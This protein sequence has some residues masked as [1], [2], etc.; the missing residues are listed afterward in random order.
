MRWAD[1]E[2]GFGLLFLSAGRHEVM[3]TRGRLYLMI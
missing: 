1:S 3:R 2:F